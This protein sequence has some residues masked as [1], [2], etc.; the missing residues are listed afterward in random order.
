VHFNQEDSD[1]FVLDGNSGDGRGY[2]GSD[3]P[4]QIEITYLDE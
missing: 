4:C 2:V 1:D 3:I